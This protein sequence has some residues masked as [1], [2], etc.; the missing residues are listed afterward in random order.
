MPLPHFTDMTMNYS[1][2]IFLKDNGFSL[3]KKISTTVYK[4]G[5]ISAHL[6]ISDLYIYHNS[7]MI[8]DY[9]KDIE[10]IKIQNTTINMTDVLNKITGVLSVLIREYKF[11]EILDERI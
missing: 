4:L 9:S 6:Y 10:L 3:S 2:S 8:Y 7:K 1:M 5:D 11:K